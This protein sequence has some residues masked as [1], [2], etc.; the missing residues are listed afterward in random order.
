MDHPTLPDNLPGKFIVFDGP[1]GCGK[2]T[3]S[4][5]FAERVRAAGGGV[6]TCRD[7]GGTAIGDRIRS[8]LL[9]YDL[10]TMDVRCEAMLFMASRAQLIAEVVEPALDRNETVVCDRFITSTCAYQGR[11][12]I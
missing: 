12:R 2:S 9:D 8:V 3:Q 11:G 5:R 10:S 4:N 6:T 7:P 1:D